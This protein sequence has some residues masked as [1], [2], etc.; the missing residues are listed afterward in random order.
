MEGAVKNLSPKDELSNDFVRKMV[1]NMRCYHDHAMIQTTK[2]K[3]RF[4]ARVRKPLEFVE[5][6][7][8]DKFFRTRRPVSTFKSADEKD[9][10]KISMKL[11]ERYEGPYQ[12]IRKISPVLY[13]ADVDGKEVRV[14]ANNMKPF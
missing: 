7:T 2:N 6:K 14:H 3:G 12:I 9:A 1:E 10:W 5:Y 8:G 11:L 13:D 4:N